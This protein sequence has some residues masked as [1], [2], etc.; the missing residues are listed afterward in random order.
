MI[1]ILF[2]FSFLSFSIASHRVKNGYR[3][4]FFPGEGERDFWVAV[5]YLKACKWDDGYVY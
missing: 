1:K 5:Q 4:V 3:L 2:L